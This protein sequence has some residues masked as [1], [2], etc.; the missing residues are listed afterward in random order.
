MKY[1]SEFRDAAAAKKIADQI[2]QQM[3]GRNPITLMEVCGTHTMAIARHG[4][5]KLLPANLTLVSGPGCPVCVTPNY[6]I[7]KAIAYARR[8]DAILATFGDMLRVPGST[9]SLEKEKASGHRVQVVYST[10]DAL[11]LA[12]QHLAL[13]I[14]FLGVGFETTAPT[15]AASIVEAARRGISNYYVFSMHKTMPQPMK[16][17]VNGRVNLDGFIC[18]GHVSVIIGSEP[19]EFL[20]RD[21]SKACVI[22]GFEPLDILEGILMLVKQIVEERPSVEIQYKRTVT[23]NGNPTALR[24]LDEVFEPCDS[25]WRGIGVIPCSG[26]KIRAEYGSYDAERNIEVEVEPTREYLGCLCGNVLQGVSIPTDCK[27][28]GTE[29]TPEDP[30]G[31]CMVSME[32]TCAAWYRYRIDSPTRDLQ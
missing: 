15:V 23:E 3:K 20:A 8:G 13:K 29:C 24:L 26:L 16:T 6:D 1:I 22:T 18:P 27:L 2:H 21:C 17:L 5:R 32:G 19:Y 28:F 11:K 30:V 12:E 25:E 9:S 7:D 10:L 14:I 4:I 31:A